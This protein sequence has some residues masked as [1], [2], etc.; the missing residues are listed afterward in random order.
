VSSN[1]DLIKNLLKPKTQEPDEEL[2]RLARLAIG[3]AIEVHR[4]LGPG[5]LEG[6]YENAL[7]IEFDLRRIPFRRQHRV[8]IV[9]K[10]RPVG[11]GKLDLIVG[12]RLIIEIKTVERLAPIH[13][14]QLISYLRMTHRK[15]GLLINFNV[16]LLRD[17]IKRVIVS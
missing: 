7:C 10:G 14:A 17:G 5:L 8:G 1:D 13:S 4:Q 12:E 3:A 2:D 9:Y 15:L 16:A 11:K 6:V